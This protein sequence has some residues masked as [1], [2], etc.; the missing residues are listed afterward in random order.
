MADGSSVELAQLVRDHLQ[1]I[2]YRDGPM[3]AGRAHPALTELRQQRIVLA[4]LV[5]CLR[6]PLGD[7]GQRSQYRGARGVYAIRGGAG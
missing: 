1:A 3:V 7:E 6:V 2:V 4:R 5:V